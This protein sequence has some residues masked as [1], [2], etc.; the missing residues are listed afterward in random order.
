MGKQRLT[1][2]CHCRW[3]VRLA[4]LPWGHT[5]TAPEGS[6]LFTTTHIYCVLNP[7]IHPYTVTALWGLQPSTT[8]KVPV[9]T[10]TANDVRLCLPSPTD[11]AEMQSLGRFAFHFIWSGGGK[12]PWEAEIPG[13]CSGTLWAGWEPP[14][15][16]R[17]PQSWA[18]LELDPGAAP[19]AIRAEPSLCPSKSS[20]GS[21]QGVAFTLL[22]NVRKHT[23]NPFGNKIKEWLI[24][25]WKNH[26]MTVIC[27]PSREV[28]LVNLSYFNQDQ[29][30][31]TNCFKSLLLRGLMTV[32]KIHLFCTRLP[33]KN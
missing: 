20:K 1:V 30:H 29:V 4:L 18:E 31:L 27:S 12:S 21:E 9:V 3:R 16:E 24:P 28:K 14:W 11:T 15:E 33:K 10:W 19:G 32:S 6:S 13:D 8:N 17:S 2:S 22:L 26:W 25:R 7:T 23:K 5:Y